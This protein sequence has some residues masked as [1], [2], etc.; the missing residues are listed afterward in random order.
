MQQQGI[1]STLNIPIA[2][3]LLLSTFALPSLF[4]AGLFALC[5]QVQALTKSKPLFWILT[6]ADMQLE[7]RK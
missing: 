7:G 1:S 6:K 5:N 4:L 2:P 3:L